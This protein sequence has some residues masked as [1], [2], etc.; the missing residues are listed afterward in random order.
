MLS[1]NSL[2][3]GSEDQSVY[4]WDVE[5]QKHTQCNTGIR[6]SEG[7]ALLSVD[8]RHLLDVSA[9]EAG[10]KKYQIE[11]IDF[12]AAAEGSGSSRRKKQ[13][14]H[15]TQSGRN[16]LQSLQ[17]DILAKKRLL[18][19]PDLSSS[20]IRASRAAC[21]HIAEYRR[22]ASQQRSVPSQL[23]N[24]YS[25]AQSIDNIMKDDTAMYLGSAGASQYL[26][27]V[28][29]IYRH[30]L[31]DGGNLQG[32]ENT[33]NVNR[34][35]AEK[36]AT[37]SLWRGDIGGALNSLAMS[38]NISADFVNSTHAFGHEVWAAVTWL[39]AQQLEAQGEVQR[40]VLQY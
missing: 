20:S 11:E 6:T 27:E 30:S 39:Y 21:A 17:S 23:L 4:V 32:R 35:N 34:G 5:H 33:G 19:I 16:G 18:P 3:S 36:A 24:G 15:D 26:R 2:F 22:Q 28:E 1:S 38:G 25:M 14:Q 29:E 10:A 40:A 37:L 8:Q 9:T 7:A 12:M 31:G 13:L